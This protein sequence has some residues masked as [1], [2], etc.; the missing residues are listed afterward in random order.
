MNSIVNNLTKKDEQIALKAAADMINGKNTEAF[1]ELCGKSDFLFDFVKN[2]VRKRIKKVITKDN[3]KNI[4]DFFSIY[5]ENYADLFA[6]LLAKYA[7][8][9]LTDEI[10]DLLENGNEDQKKYSAK[11]FYYIP[12]TIAAET[13]QKY[14]F[15]NDIQL[16][17][18]SAQ[19]LGEMDERTSYNKA[20][21][22]LEL[23][24]DFEVMK[25]V[26]FLTAFGD[27]S[28]VTNLLKTLEK[29]TMAE[30]IASEIPYLMPILDMIETQ[31]KTLVLTCF[32]FIL[33]GLGEILP[34]S[35]IFDFQVFEML[36]YLI[37]IA[38]Q[39]NSSHIAQILLRALEKF[40]TLLSNDEYIFDETND[41][42]EEIKAVFKLLKDQ[43]KDF[44]EK[45]KLLISKELKETK[46]RNIGALEVIRALEIKEAGNELLEFIHNQKDEQ[47]LV[48]AAGTAKVLGLISKIDS[49]KVIE[50]ITNPTSKAIIMSYFL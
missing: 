16:A 22:M 20:L 38:K 15:S 36:D 18:N 9:D 19:A 49:S 42:K 17:V 8:E 21:E 37:N 5:D 29:T 7:D 43:P 14:A 4:L 33:V 40:S 13:L 41:T 30:N 25:A 50:K 31:D 34:L 23:D 6:E 35:Q 24:D 1:A 45:Q 48:L 46:Q 39:T 26:R 3:Y 27:K 12:D 32:D 47:L 28:S 10:F 44:W 11:Y 2:N